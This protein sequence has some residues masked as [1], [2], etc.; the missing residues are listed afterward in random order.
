MELKE[1]GEELKKF[2]L[3]EEIIAVEFIKRI[4]GKHSAVLD[5]SN[6]HIF[7]KST[8]LLIKVLKSSF[9][10]QKQ[11]KKLICKIA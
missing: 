10:S 5:L 2:K 9:N 11:I 3:T 1:I 8:S 4:F 6:H 7:E